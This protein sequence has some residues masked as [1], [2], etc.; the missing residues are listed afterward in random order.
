MV[1]QFNSRP[2]IALVANECPIQ[3]PLTTSMSSASC[4]C[5][6][7][8][9]YKRSDCPKCAVPCSTR[10]SSTFSLVYNSLHKQVEHTKSKA[11]FRNDQ[12]YLVSGLEYTLYGMIK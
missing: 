12:L 4:A 11:L 9:G 2:C 5:L 1:L 3:I 10:V 8:L 6:S 7:P